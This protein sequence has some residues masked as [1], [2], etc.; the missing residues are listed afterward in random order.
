MPLTLRAILET[1]PPP[2]RFRE[3]ALELKDLISWLLTSH[4]LMRFIIDRHV[5][6]MHNRYHYSYPGE[7]EQ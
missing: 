5:H 6:F 7:L 1:C 2:R 4:N 3:S